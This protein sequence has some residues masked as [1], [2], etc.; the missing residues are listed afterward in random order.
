MVHVCNR[1]V[2]RHLLRYRQDKLDAFINAK[3]SF[4]GVFYLSPSERQQAKRKGK[5][6]GRD[7]W[8]DLIGEE[9]QKQ[10]DEQQEEEAELEE[11]RKEFLLTNS[12]E[13]FDHPDFFCL[14]ACY[15]L[16]RLLPRQVA[17]LAIQ[18]ELQVLNPNRYAPVLRYS[19]N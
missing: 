15:G 7:R 12:P 13:K 5:G 19:F 2:W 10:V 14:E 3:K 17:Q 8:Q 16:R 4:R 9:G 1:F 18:R 11:D 6:K